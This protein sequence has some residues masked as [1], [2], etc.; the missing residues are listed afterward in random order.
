[1][2]VLVIQQKMIG[3]VLTSS[4]LFE[5]LKEKYP[6]AELHYVLN[7]H[8][9]PVVEHNPFIDEF[10]FVTPEIE[11]SKVAFYGFLKTIRHKNY[12]AVIDVY[13]KY[14]SNLMTLFSGAKLKISKRKWYTSII[15]NHNYTDQ[16]VKK[17]KAGLAIENR[18][19]LLEPLHIKTSKLYKP[20]IH[21]T[22][23]EITESK[24][25]LQQSGIDLNKPIYMIGVLGSGMNK[26]Y[27]FEYMAKV[28]DVIASESK[29]QI[30]FNYIPKQENNAKQIFDLCSAEAQNQIYFKVFGNSL[31]DFLAITHHCKALIGNEGGAIN[32]AKAINIP[33][34]TIFSPWIKKEV[35]SS[36]E[37][38]VQN[39]SVHLKDF[40]PHFFKNKDTRQLKAHWKTLYSEFEPDLL[41]AKLKKFV[42]S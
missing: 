28:I 32:M 13:S 18:I 21:L 35:W 8:T 33:T 25:F 17:T 3:D 2:R 42:S 5:A 6:N 23:K 30:L 36:F 7:K 12:D 24:V 9:Y 10:L 29:G 40:K 4:I 34:F 16:K 31:R 15:Y 26:T 37:D 27:P 41:Q 14:S 20:K 11:K 38:D 22:N 39:V 1:M 19:Q